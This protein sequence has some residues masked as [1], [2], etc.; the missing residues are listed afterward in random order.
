[1]SILFTGWMDQPFLSSCLD[2]GLL[3]D[4]TIDVVTFHGYER[5][6]WPG[7]ARPVD[8]GPGE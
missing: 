7:S 5:R 4:R 8:R 6:M 2:L 3:K 1:V